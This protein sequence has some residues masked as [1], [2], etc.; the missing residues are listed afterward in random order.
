[1]AVGGSWGIN[2]RLSVELHRP[3]VVSLPPPIATE[4]ME[5]GTT[6]VASLMCPSV[7]CVYFH[8]SNKK[9][10]QQKNR[11]SVPEDWKPCIRI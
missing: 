7:K 8:I 2:K 9:K 3:V 11:R 4:H 10:T 6:P 5:P 1:M